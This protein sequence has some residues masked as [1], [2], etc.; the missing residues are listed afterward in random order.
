MPVDAPYICV[1]CK[2][3]KDIQVAWSSRSGA[4]KLLSRTGAS[5][6][7]DCDIFWHILTS[8]IICK[9]GR[10][11]AVSWVTHKCPI[12]QGIG[13]TW[14]PIF[15]RLVRT[16]HGIPA[17][18]PPSSMDPQVASFGAGCLQN[19]AAAGE[20]ECLGCLGHPVFRREKNM[21]QSI[22][23]GAPQL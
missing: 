16:C 6:D 9:S 19:A 18:P 17:A 23:D 13:V 2:H 14:C 11:S 4:L 10:A 21:E 15:S 22:Q 3:W 12:C 1:C 7:N 8:Y 5:L 20:L